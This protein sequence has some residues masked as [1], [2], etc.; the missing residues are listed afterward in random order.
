[1]IYGVWIECE[2]MKRGAM[3]L[4]RRPE[5]SFMATSGGVTCGWEKFFL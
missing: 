2:C 4:C 3:L 1:M 5:I